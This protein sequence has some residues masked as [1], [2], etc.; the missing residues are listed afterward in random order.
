VAARGQQESY[1]K[2]QEDHGARLCDKHGPGLPGRRRPDRTVPDE[3]EGGGSPQQT[4]E[5]CTGQGSTK[6]REHVGQHVPA[7]EG[8][9]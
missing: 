1:D 8:V 2:D 9:H 5:T 7:R 4:R 6:L 3:R